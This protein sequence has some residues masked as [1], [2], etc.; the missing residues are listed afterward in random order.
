MKGTPHDSLGYRYF[1]T[2]SNESPDEYDQYWIRYKPVRAVKAQNS[3]PASVENLTRLFL[4]TILI[5]GAMTGMPVLALAILACLTVFYC[6]RLNLLFCPTHIA[7][8]EEGMQLHW[9]R[10]WLRASSLLIPWSRLSH[11]S[12]VKDNKESQTAQKGTARKNNSA[13]V[14]FNVVTRGLPLAERLKFALVSPRAFG[15]WMAGDRARIVLALEGLASSDDRKRLQFA[16]QRYLPS[17]MVEPAVSDELNLAL[18]VDSYTDIWLDAFSQ[19]AHRLRT[20]SL[21]CGASLAG[22]KYRVVSLIGSGGQAVVYLATAGVATGGASEQAV[23]LKEFV[24]PSQAGVNVRKRVLENIK[25]ESA[26]LKDLSHPNIVKL[27]DFFVEDQRAYLVVEQIKGVTLKEHVKTNG[28]VKEED[29]ISYGLQ[30]CTILAYLHS[31][32]PAV[33]HRDFTPDNL[34]LAYGD[35][36]KLIDFNV[37]QHLESSSTK[38][39]VGKHAFIPPEQFRGEAT[40]QSDIYAMGATLYYLL[41]GVEPEPISASYPK[42]KRSDLSEELNQVVAKA[43][44]TDAGYRYLDCSEI[45]VELEELRKSRYGA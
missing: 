6:L 39:V 20:E 25:R 29:A 42:D 41:T 7:L 27:L 19:S 9:L 13:R 3:S 36:I 37:A 16:F 26:I 1:F 24:L 45:R 15:E 14:E 17:Y 28:P 18:R 43:T 38:L 31:R 44:A 30:M 34:M 33:I 40:S 8:T 32:K 11:V 4:V 2:R 35:I 23:V 12:L 5:C 21:S 22:G 10:S